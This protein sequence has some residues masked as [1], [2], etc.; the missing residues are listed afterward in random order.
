MLIL[1]VLLWVGPYFE[2]LP[3]CVL[4]SIIFVALKGMLWQVL[5]IK[6][7]HREGTLEL[8]VWLVTFLSVTI[9]DIDIGLL[10]G[11]VFSLLV[12]YI[13]GWKSYYSLLGTVPETA[14]YVDIGSH[15]RA[16]ELPHIK[17]FKYFGAINFASRS[18]FKKALTKEVGVCQKLVHRASKY[19]SAGEG[20]G[21]HII[22]TVIIDLSSVPH[23]DTAACKTF[24]EIKKEMSGVGVNT[25]IANP[26]DCVY[27]TLLHAESIGEGGFHIF[28]TTHD[29][30]LY[31]QG[32]V[33]SV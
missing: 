30:V 29:A 25:L 6:K 9:I 11:V 1:V 22:K 31:A 7:F 8:F 13:K 21:L 19:D 4:A 14:I 3:R 28:P 5:H 27:D 2:T 10:V 24:S 12:L 23:I 33:T 17:I 16:E 15:Q 18:G 26:A 20:A 32:S